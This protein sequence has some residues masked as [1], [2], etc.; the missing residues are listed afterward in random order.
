MFFNLFLN[1]SKTLKNKEANN[2]NKRLSILLVLSSLCFVACDNND[3]NKPS[4][5]VS[6]DSTSG[7]YS[8][9]EESIKNKQ[10]INEV[11]LAFE[12]R[13][14]FEDVPLKACRREGVYSTKT[15]EWSPMK[16]TC[17][18]L[19]NINNQLSKRYN[20]DYY[21][22]AINLFFDKVLPSFKEN[23]VIDKILNSFTYEDNGVNKI[24]VTKEEDY[25]YYGEFVTSYTEQ[26]YFKV[27]YLKQ[28]ISRANSNSDWIY[29]IKEKQS[30]EFTVFVKANMMPINTSVVKFD[31]EASYLEYVKL[32]NLI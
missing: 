5:T 4:I 1:H 3:T 10:V 8:E 21:G 32:Y 27:N 24:E 6:F 23:P 18:Y 15:V 29:E 26:Y 19:E 22:T 16:V 2:M 20:Y 12:N 30:F 9:I 17:S 28:E 25:G 31:N 7:T 14:H 11:Q 13:G